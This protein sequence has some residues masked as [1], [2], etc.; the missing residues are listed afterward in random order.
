MFERVQSGNN[1]SP[2][3]EIEVYNTFFMTKSCHAFVLQ[4]KTKKQ[5]KLALEIIL[6]KNMC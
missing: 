3:K 1:R 6:Y 4:K 5:N 2:V